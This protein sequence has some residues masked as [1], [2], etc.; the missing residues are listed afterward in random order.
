VA[1]RRL[2]ATLDAIG[3]CLSARG[4]APVGSAIVTTSA[5]DAVRRYL[6]WIEDPDTAVDAEAIEAAE[7]AFASASDPIARLHAAAARERAA[8]AD[9]TAIE[10][11]FVAHAKGYA[12]ANAS[13]GFQASRSYRT[14]GAH[15]SDRRGHRLHRPRFPGCLWHRGVPPAP[16]G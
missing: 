12:D 16:G 1:A 10:A 9:V 7:A 2:T 15:P 6:A 3:R 5:E 14:S 11:D 4:G 13:T 8:T